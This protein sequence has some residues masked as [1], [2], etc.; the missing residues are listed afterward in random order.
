MALVNSG[1][2]QARPSSEALQA[3]ASG[4][5]RL[6]GRAAGYGTRACDRRAAARQRKPDASATEAMI[7]ESWLPCQATGDRPGSSVTKRAPRMAAA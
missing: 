2:A 5:K 7:C 3:A 1:C 6:Q 4:C